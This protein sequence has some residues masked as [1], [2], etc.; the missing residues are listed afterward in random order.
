MV[1]AYTSPNKGQS[2]ES[3]YSRY[4]KSEGAGFLRNQH[5]AMALLLLRGWKSGNYGYEVFGT[6]DAVLSS[7]YSEAEQGKSWRICNQALE[8]LDVA[9]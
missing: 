8:D 5:L 7:N 4:S 1:M 2:Q 6:Q 3:N 9:R